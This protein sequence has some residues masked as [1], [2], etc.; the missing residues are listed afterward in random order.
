MQTAAL[1]YLNVSGTYRPYEVKPNELEKMF[2][3]LKGSGIKGFNVTIPHKISI[4]PLLD[5]LTERAKL[6]GAVNTVTFNNGKAIGDNT[7]V[8]GFWEA[9]PEEIRKIIPEKNISI[10]PRDFLKF[11]SFSLF[12]P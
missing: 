6:I 1:Q 10:A 5:E 8:I 2:N 7:D 9:I 11:A 12:R 4:I 3:Q